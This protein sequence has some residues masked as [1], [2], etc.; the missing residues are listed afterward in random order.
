MTIKP[1]LTS[2]VRSRCDVSRVT[3]KI[4]A[5]L[6]APYTEHAHAGVRSSS[7]LVDT[8]PD[9]TAFQPS[10]ACA[11]EP[12]DSWVSSLRSSG[13]PSRASSEGPAGAICA[14]SA[15]RCR[16]SPPPPGV[17]PGV[18]PGPR[19][20]TGI[21]RGFTRF[22]RFAPRLAA[23]RRCAAL[24]RLGRGS[25]ASNLLRSTRLSRDES[26]RSLDWRRSRT[27]LGLG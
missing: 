10:A 19:G 22:E 5:H 25:G 24:A 18:P 4:N 7:F 9:G 3:H 26:R 23:L 1:Y 2:D 8:C 13:L 6:D 12:A 16:W 27:W 17:P 15:A 11:V 20:D 14:A 21:W